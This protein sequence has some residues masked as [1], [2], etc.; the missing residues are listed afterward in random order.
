[1]ATP[2][3]MTVGPYSTIRKAGNLYFISGAIGL[4]LTTKIADPDILAQTAQTLD[5]LETVLVGAGLTLANVVKTTIF[6]TDIGDF[7][8]VNAVYAKRFD[9]PYPARSAVAVSELP[10]VASVPL[11][12]EIEAIASLE[13]DS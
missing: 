8:A 12:I 4:D 7:A 11:K 5:N 6:L 1:M 9:L 3:N 2:S 10:R 13:K